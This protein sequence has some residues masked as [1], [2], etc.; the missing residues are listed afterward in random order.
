MD[1]QTLLHWPREWTLSKMQE[2]SLSRSAE[3]WSAYSIDSMTEYFVLLFEFRKLLQL[4]SY[5]NLIF[6]VGCYG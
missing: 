6:N 4:A 5:S 1:S 2:L 3:I